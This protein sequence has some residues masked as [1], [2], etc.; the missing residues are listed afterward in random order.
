MR[1]ES[2]KSPT[3][4]K[5]TDLAAARIA[6]KKKAWHARKALQ[7]AKSAGRPQQELEK[8]TENILYCEV[9]ANIAARA[10]TALCGHPPEDDIDS[11]SE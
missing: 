7:A 8:I 11:E 6:A 2:G 9:R 10:Y 4:L 1:D 5:L 3:Q